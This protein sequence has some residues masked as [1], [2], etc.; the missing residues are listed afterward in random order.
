M[1]KLEEFAAFAKSRVPAKVYFRR[2]QEGHDTVRVAALVKR[3]FPLLLSP[4]MPKI[5]ERANA[6]A[7]RCEAALRKFIG[8]FGSVVLAGVEERV[9]AI[10]PTSAPPT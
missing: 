8:V 2:T 1:K 10:P 6:A 5:R 9:R 3:I 4:S 7:E